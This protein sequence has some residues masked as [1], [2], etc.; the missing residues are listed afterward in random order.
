MD[1]PARSRRSDLAIEVD[2]LTHE[3]VA[4]LGQRLRAARVRRRVTQAQ[5]GGMVGLS[6]SEIS[7]LELGQGSGAPI[8]VW[9]ALA[10]VIGLQPRF[11]F[12]RDWRDEPVDAGHLAVQELLLRLARVGGAVGR[13]ELPV[14]SSDPTHFVDVLVRDDRR[15]RLIV[16]EAWNS[17]HDIGA[18]VRSFQ[19]KL[20]LARDLAIS[21]G[22]DRPYTVHGVWVVRAT[23][24]NRDLIARY[25]EIF[26]RQF[27]GSSRAW[28]NALE[29]G[30]QPPDEPGLV[31]CDGRAT[32]LIPWRRRYSMTTP[33]RSSSGFG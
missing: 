3:T 11:E 24:R 23:K 27:P 32:R 12:A 5:L 21:S 20:A 18:S 6:Q 4:R 19:R 31:W 26:G 29:R 16:E 10:A 28:V 9:L 1:G 8:G 2:R 13:F 15:R 7:R 17:I 25:P 30:T 22:G 33:S 14:G